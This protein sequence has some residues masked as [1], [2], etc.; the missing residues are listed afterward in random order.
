MSQPA[1]LRRPLTHGAVGL[2]A[3][4]LGIL[5]HPLA[6]A[7]G[8]LGVVVGWV[9][10]PRTPWEAR[11]RR[12][13][14]SFLGGLRTY[15]VAVLILILWL[16]PANAAAAWGVLAFGDAAAS[17]VGQ[18]V[19]A[20]RLFGHPKATI[21]GS[22][23]H[24]LVGAA[25]AFALGQGAEALGD[26]TGWVETGSAPGIMR[27]ALAALGAAVLDLVPIPPDDNIPGALAAGAVL[28]VTTTL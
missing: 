24:V 5:P 17:I 4:S 26:L 2:F 19:P 15:P 11:L 13:G 7:G 21:S 18:R 28:S 3:L 8:V 20:P 14:E 12:P 22:G 6:I 1:S 9:I 27:C 16:S 25:A 10:L 23:A